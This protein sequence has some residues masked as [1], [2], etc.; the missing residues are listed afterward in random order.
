MKKKSGAFRTRPLIENAHVQRQL[1][2]AEGSWYA[3]HAG[4]EQALV[5]LWRD[6][7]KSRRVPIETRLSLL[8]A[9]A[10]AAATGI[11]IIE[12][13]CDVVGTSI[14]P[15]R[16]RFGACLRDARTLGSHASVSGAL[17]E[18]ATQLKAGLTNEVPWI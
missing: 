15:A 6:A 7:E 5:R 8:A 3:C 13:M 11:E 2:R 14:A 4:V 16:G 17:L 10:H 9:N 12:S 18:M 1:M